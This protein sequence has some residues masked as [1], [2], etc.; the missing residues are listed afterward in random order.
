MVA[1][2]DKERQQWLEKNRDMAASG[3]RVLAFARRD[4]IDSLK[5]VKWE[6]FILVGLVGLLD[7]PRAEVRESIQRCQSAG[8]RIV[9]VTG[10]QAIT[11]QNIAYETG[12]V[13][14]ESS[15]VINGDEL[16]DLL[17]E[18]EHNR[19]KILATQIF[20]RVTPAQ[21]LALVKLYQQSGQVVAMTGDG[22]NDAPALKK[23]D[24]GIAM[25]HR[26]T[27]V[28]R[29][30]ADMVLK[31]DSF[32]T[33]AMAVEQGRIIFNNLRRFVVYL[34]SCNLSEVLILSV[35]PRY[36]PYLCPCY[37]CRFCFSIW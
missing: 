6:D 12:I 26:G 37:R 17:A 4:N 7:P 34:L 20:S 13:E 30:A 32:A 24:I 3:L 23:A 18:L 8:I 35:S 14:A 29:D 36:L 2:S 19:A 28:A 22:V 25:G 1:L 16:D 5:Q 21:K 15:P 31:D 9:M 11:A 33:I 10:D 27:Q